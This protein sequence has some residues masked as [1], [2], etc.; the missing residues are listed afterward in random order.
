MEKIKRDEFIAGWPFQLEAIYSPN[1]TGQKHGTQIQDVVCLRYEKLVNIDICFR[2]R[3]RWMLLE[4]K[5]KG[6]Y[7]SFIYCIF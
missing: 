6:H 5:F 7:R 2:G 4:F 1:S 3:D